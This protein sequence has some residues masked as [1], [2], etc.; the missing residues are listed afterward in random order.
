MTIPKEEEEEE[1]EEEERISFPKLRAYGRY[2]VRISELQ[3]G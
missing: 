1:Q 3:R 2:L